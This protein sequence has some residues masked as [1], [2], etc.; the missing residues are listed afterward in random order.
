DLSVVV[1]T[2][3][4]IEVSP[5]DA[6]GR[7]VPAWITLWDE[8]LDAYE[9]RPE[10]PGGRS[11]FRQVPLGRRWTIQAQGGDQHHSIVIDGPRNADEPVAIEMPLP[12]RR[13]DLAARV[14]R[15]DGVAPGAGK[16]R[17]R[18]AELPGDGLDFTV[19]DDGRVWFGRIWLPAPAR[20]LTMPVLEID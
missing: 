16:L 12:F 9:L 1:P 15:S 14:V 18:C 5:V 6:D 4:T 17:L 11:R 13:W 8:A 7:P 3:G 19:R 2:G 20:R 10:E